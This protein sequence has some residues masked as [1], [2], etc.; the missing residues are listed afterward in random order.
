MIDK[1]YSAVVFDNILFAPD[2]IVQT[3]QFRPLS[4]SKGWYTEKYIDQLYSLFFFKEKLRGVIPSDL[5]SFGHFWES[6]KKIKKSSMTLVY[7]N[8][9]WNPS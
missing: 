7:W 2:L 6:W 4:G 8:Q 5:K 3:Y 1:Y 9:Y